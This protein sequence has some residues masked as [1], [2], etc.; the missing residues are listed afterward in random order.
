MNMR[1]L[2]R[3]FG[4]SLGSILSLA[5]LIGCGQGSLGDGPGASGGG[6]GVPGDPADPPP[7]VWD[8]PPIPPRY[9]GLLCNPDIEIAADGRALVVTDPEVL[10]RFSLERVVTQIVDRSNKAVS[11]E[12]LVRR[13][14]DAQ[15]DAANAVFADNAHCDDVASGASQN[16]LAVDCPRAEGAL[17]SSE[18]LFQ[19]DHPDFFAPVAIV[20]RFDLT[21]SEGATCGEYRIVYAKWSGRT[22][23]NDRVFLIFEAKILNLTGFDTI[24]DCRPMAEAWAALADEPDVEAVADRLDTMF[25]TGI[26][27]FGPIVQPQHY[28]I[29]DPGNDSYGGSRGQIRVSQRMQEPWEMREYLLRDDPSPNRLPL[30]FEPVPVK[31]NPI[32]ELFDPALQTQLAKNFRNEFVSQN[33]PLLGGM[34]PRGSRMRVARAFNA[35]ESAVS[36]DASVDYASIAFSSPQTPFQGDILIRIA[37]LG[38]DAACPPGDPLTPESIVRRATTQT[39]AGCH[40]PQRFL[41]PERSLGCGEVFPAT[42]GEVHIDEWGTLSPALKDVFLPQ[43]AKV[44]SLYLQGCDVDAILKNLDDP[45]IPVILD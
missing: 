8:E 24:L 30:R 21:P 31:N 5:F 33:V 7:D 10:A 14:F 3:P 6:Q 15:N 27:G 42:L 20:N 22:N 4:R 12:E 35:G 45:D 34:D 19:P 44:M 41:G 16:G 1:A 29:I 18:G 25:F 37:E 32:P 43:R 36:G 28:G 23:P 38:L 17:A 2:E 13:L 26:A 40:A 9:P 39:C 11:P